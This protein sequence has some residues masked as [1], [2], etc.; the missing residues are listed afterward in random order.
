MERLL[1]DYRA[2]KDIP[3]VDST[4]RGIFDPTIE[5]IIN[6]TIRGL[7]NG[8]DSLEEIRKLREEVKQPKFIPVKVSQR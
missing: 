5:G 4:F 7:E 6:Q 2:V 1:N 8:R 3:N